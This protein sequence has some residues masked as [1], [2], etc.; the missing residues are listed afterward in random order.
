MNSGISDICFRLVRPSNGK[1]GFNW[2]HSV[3]IGIRMDRYSIVKHEETFICSNWPSQTQISTYF[4]VW[5]PDNASRKY[6]THICTRF[7]YPRSN[8]TVVDFSLIIFAN[9]YNILFFI[10]ETDMC[11][12]AWWNDGEK[13]YAESKGFCFFPFAKQLSKCNIRTIITIRRMHMTIRHAIRDI[14]SWVC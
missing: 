3:T 12:A 2:M 4:N 10:F 1:I 5:M 11:T 13:N 14:S 7:L 9:T 6:Y 8:R